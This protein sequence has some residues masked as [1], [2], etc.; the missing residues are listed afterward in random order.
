M[1][2]WGG[3]VSIILTRV[4]AGAFGDAF[5]DPCP[6]PGNA[7]CGTDEGAFG[8]RLRGEIPDVP[9][10]LLPREVPPTLAVLD[11]LE[12]CHRY[13][14][15]AEQNYYHRYFRHHHLEFDAVNG[16]AEFRQDVNHVLARNGL[17]YELGADGLVTR[18][19]PPV[20]R[21]ALQAALFRTGDAVLDTLL[22]SARGKYLDPDP[23][24]RRE[25]LEKLW[26][27]W[28]RLKT[29]EPGP[30]KKAS[31]NALLD[32]TTA[33]ST[34]RNILHDEARALTGIGNN[35]Q[36]RHSE[37]GKVPI[38]ATEQV[39]YLFHRLFALI[40]LLLMATGR[41]G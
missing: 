7:S 31:V 3:L 14:A 23:S 17:V 16:R 12:F 15:R 38:H 29:V 8:L 1:E 41:G 28:E 11:L 27:A 24:V 37:V 5:P 34:L 18:L 13:V 19:A 30:D 2:A 35:F 36:I 32:R 6:D 40:R 25:S 4:A 9:W 20:L 33:E 21:E 26:D 22:E 39:D 10:P